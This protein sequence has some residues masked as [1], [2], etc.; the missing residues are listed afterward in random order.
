MSLRI[1][2]PFYPVLGVLLAMRVSMQSMGQKTAPVISSVIELIMKV[3][4]AIWLIPAYGFLGTC[5]TEPVTWILMAA[6]LLAV[7]M[8]KTRK[9][10][11]DEEPV[12]PAAA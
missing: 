4:A 7:Y 6:F 1:H 5:I 11:A 3:M 2:F 12:H 9:L 10:L 8:V